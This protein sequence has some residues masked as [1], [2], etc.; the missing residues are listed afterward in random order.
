M[1]TVEEALQRSAVAAHKRAHAQPITGVVAELRELLTPKLVASIAGVGETRATRQW[2]EGQR[3]PHQETQTRLRTALQA[4]LVIS[5]AY[6]ARTA[7]AWMQGID[8]AL[9]DR[10]PATVLRDSVDD[11]DRQAVVVSAQRFAI[12]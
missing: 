5:E 8:P 4:T 1:S 7:Q 2:A 6:D 9:G 12:Q 3:A 11:A 10:S